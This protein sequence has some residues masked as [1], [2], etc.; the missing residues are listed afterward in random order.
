MPAYRVTVPDQPTIR[1]ATAAELP[2]IGRSL[3]AAFA[4]DPVWEWLTKGNQD[5][6]RRTAPAFFEAD[7]KA[8][9]SGPGEVLVDDQVGGVALWAAPDHWKGTFRQMLNVT[10]PAFRMMGPRTARGLAGLTGLEKAHPAEPHWYLSL[11][12]TDP[13]HQG[14]GIGSALIRTVT[15]R[16]DEQG[17]PAYLESSKESNVPYY[18]RFGFEV[19]SVHRFAKGGPDLWL[20]WREPR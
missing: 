18:A 19:T 9:M 1:A 12:G 3:A 6:Y 17:I 8:M 5:R 2:A 20:M 13:A 7:A 10:V 16:C 11:L 4:D 15:D 14:R